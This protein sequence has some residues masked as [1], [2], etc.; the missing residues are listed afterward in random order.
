MSTTKS[1]SRS[2]SISFSPSHPGTPIRRAFLL[3]ATLNLFTLP[4]LTHPRPIL[5]LL[6]A[7]PTH[8][9]PAA[10]LFA[11]LFGA[12]VLGAQTPALLIG[13]TN[14]RNGIE[15]RR[16]TYAL[17]GLGEVACMLVL[18]REVLKGEGGRDAALSDGVALGCVG[19]LAPTLVW[20]VFVL[21][22]M[23]MLLGRYTEDGGR[24]GKGT[25]S[26]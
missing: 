5:H 22:V 3:E 13:A 15:S 23:S 19:V 9:T 20:R 8:I 26:E 25:K 7:N 2:A 10:V 11:R 6:L 14:T 21:F 12:L 24:M 1:P 4:L 17:L 16:P 18:V